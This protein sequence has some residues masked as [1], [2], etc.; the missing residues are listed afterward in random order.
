MSILVNRPPQSSY[1]RRVAHW[2][3]ELLGGGLEIDVLF[4]RGPGQL[5]PRAAVHFRTF[6]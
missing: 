3:S 6:H 5:L 4:F 1:R 2:L